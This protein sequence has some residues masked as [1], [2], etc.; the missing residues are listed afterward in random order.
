MQ[1]VANMRKDG[2]SFSGTCSHC[3]RRVTNDTVI[4]VSPEI[5]IEA[6]LT[7]NFSASTTSVAVRDDYAAQPG[8]KLEAIL[9]L[10]LNDGDARRWRPEEF[11]ARLERMLVADNAATAARP[12]KPPAFGDK[13]KFLIFAEHTETLNN[14]ET[15]LTENNVVCA[16][17]QG[18]S[19][20]IAGVVRGYQDPAGTRALLV[21]STEHCAGLNLQNTTDLVFAQK[22]SHSEVERQ[23]LGR[24][25]RPG[26]TH[27]LKVHYV[28]FPNELTAMGITDRQ[29][30]AREEAIQ[31][32]V[33][34]FDTN[35]PRRPV[36][37]RAPVRPP[38]PVVDDDGDIANLTEEQQLARAMRRSRHT[39]KLETGED[40][41]GDDLDED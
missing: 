40:L 14:I 12:E 37:Q 38:Q 7:D 20:E 16:V 23:V 24:A 32:D 30:I 1:S 17:L 2:N 25:I 36:V 4:V 10:V 35:A 26:R 15:S 8:S 5:G 28:M 22:L 39:Y 11:R 19:T 3:K 34:Q 27:M 13:R 21:N 33:H 31:Q 18:T 9:D 41:S 29:I 6:I